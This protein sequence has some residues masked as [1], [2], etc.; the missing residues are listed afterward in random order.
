MLVLSEKWWDGELPVP[1]KFRPMNRVMVVLEDPAMYRQTVERAVT[2]AF[3]PKDR[4]TVARSEDGQPKVLHLL[5][6]HNGADRVPAMRRAVVVAASKAVLAGRVRWRE[7]YAYSVTVPTVDGSRREVEQGA[8]RW[9]QT[10]GLKV[11]DVVYY[12]SPNVAKQVYE[13]DGVEYRLIGG[14]Q[15]EWVEAPDGVD[16]TRFDLLRPISDAEIEASK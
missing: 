13:E 4:G 11:G 5:E 7:S 16:V 8:T 1:R 3:D 2:D 14:H 12:T 10:E 6:R 15:V 9:A